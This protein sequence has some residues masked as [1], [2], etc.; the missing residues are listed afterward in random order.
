MCVSLHETFS[1]V[2]CSFFVSFSL[3]FPSSSVSS[4]ATLDMVWMVPDF[5][6][7]ICVAVIFWDC[8]PKNLVHYGLCHHSLD[9]KIYAMLLFEYARQWGFF[10]CQTVMTFCR[11]YNSGQWC[12]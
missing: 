2:F 4:A 1:V 3:F 7:W 11:A 10:L 9:R 8:M 12:L 6:I 5:P